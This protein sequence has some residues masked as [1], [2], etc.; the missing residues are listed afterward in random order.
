MQH[1]GYSADMQ[2]R[3]W[4]K[5]DP[6][7]DCWEWIGARKPTGYGSFWISPSR[8]NEISHRVAYQMLVG[9][10]PDGLELDHLCRNRCCVNPDHLEPVT[11][12][13]NARRGV[14]WPRHAH[15]THCKHG[16]EF[17]PENTRHGKDGVRYCRACARI[18]NAKW[19]AKAA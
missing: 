12:K 18:S 3:F 9:P 7:G 11:R 2:A 1:A 5:V 14:R 8:S 6:S 19:R 16:H 15:R 17:T 4:A 13:E 10:I